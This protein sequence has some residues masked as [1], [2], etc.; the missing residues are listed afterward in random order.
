MLISGAAL[1]L[2]PD[3][4]DAAAPPE[5]TLLRAARRAMATQFEVMLPLGSPDGA[6]AAGEALDLIDELEDQ[7]TVFREHSE[8]SRLNQQAPAEDVPVESR[9]FDL[10]ASSAHLTRE[11]NGAF[12][13]AV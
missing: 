2:W 6:I 9:L 13:I 4:I 1:A 5:M 3:S 8:V 10:L 12:D 11:T 7:L